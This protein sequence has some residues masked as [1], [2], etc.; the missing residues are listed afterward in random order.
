MTILLA[1]LVKHMVKLPTIWPGHHDNSLNLNDI[2]DI[3]IW[4]RICY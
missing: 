2:R 1:S 4:Q 3:F